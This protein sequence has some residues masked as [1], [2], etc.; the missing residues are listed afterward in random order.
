M[1][2]SHASAISAMNMGTYTGIAHQTNWRATQKPPQEKIPRVSVTWG[3]KG[4]E[5]SGTKRKS[6]RMGN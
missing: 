2:M 1:N 5:E 6:T 4:K 3:A